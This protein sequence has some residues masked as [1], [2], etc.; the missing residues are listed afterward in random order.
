MRDKQEELDDLQEQL[1]QLKEGSLRGLEE[2]KERNRQQQEAKKDALNQLR[3]SIWSMENELR[4]YEQQSI[5]QNEALVQKQ[6]EFVPN[7]EYEQRFQREIDGMKNPD[8]E[9]LGNLAVRKFYDAGTKKKRNTG[10][11][12]KSAVTI[13]EN[14]QI[15][16]FL[17]LRKTI[18]IMKNC[19]SS[20]LVI[21][22]KNT[23][24]ELPHRQ[25]QR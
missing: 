9:R 22:W 5:D 21:I 25:K 19:T 11:W 14:I 1:N 18:R 2:E 15:V 12:W 3:E 23:G 8:Y 4:E 17:Q 16:H 20:Y 7:G 13:C 6:Q 10:S 24:L